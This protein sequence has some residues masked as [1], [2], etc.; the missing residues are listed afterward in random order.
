VRGFSYAASSFELDISFYIK[1]SLV[2]EPQ[3]AR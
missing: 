3:R 2:R 1:Y